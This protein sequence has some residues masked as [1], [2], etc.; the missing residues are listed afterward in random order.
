METTPDQPLRGSG[1]F[2]LRQVVPGETLANTAYWHATADARRPG[3]MS[4]THRHAVF[5]RTGQR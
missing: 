1:L 5:E 3:K 4:D 2:S